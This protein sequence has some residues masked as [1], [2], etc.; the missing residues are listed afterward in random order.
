ML[1]TQMGLIYINMLNEDFS[2]GWYN[3][4]EEED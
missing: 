1:G 3:E 4:D 2:L